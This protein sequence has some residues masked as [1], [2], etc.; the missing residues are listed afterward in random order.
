MGREVGFQIKDS[1][2]REGLDLQNQNHFG[3]SSMQ[4][5]WA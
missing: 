2:E 3:Y 4:T 1:R 5:T